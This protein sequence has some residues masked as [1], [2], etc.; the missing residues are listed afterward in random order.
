MRS[1]TCSVPFDSSTWIWLES[2]SIFLND[3]AFIA[4]SSFIFRKYDFP[5]L[6][7]E[8][9]PCILEML[10][11]VFATFSLSFWSPWLFSRTLT[12]NSSV[13]LNLSSFAR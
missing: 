9:C 7:L 12:P 5:F 8:T 1:A 2:S 10:F 6:A 13:S 3:S 11:E 4:S